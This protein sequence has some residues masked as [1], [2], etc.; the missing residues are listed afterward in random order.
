MVD[1]V[2]QIRRPILI[3]FSLELLRLSA[4]SCLSPS[5]LGIRNSEAF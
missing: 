3:F 4:F 5:V 1:I 2:R